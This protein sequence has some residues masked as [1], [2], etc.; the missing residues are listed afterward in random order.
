[1]ASANSD[2]AEPVFNNS[3][4][5]SRRYS[6]SLTLNQQKAFYE[7]LEVLHDELSLEGSSIESIRDEETKLRVQAIFFAVNCLRHGKR[8]PGVLTWDES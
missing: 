6:D 7:I 3:T 5:T 1:M 8:K 4:S 2:T